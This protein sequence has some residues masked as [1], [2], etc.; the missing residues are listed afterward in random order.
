MSGINTFDSELS[1][2]G[3][4]VVVVASRFND[5]VVDKLIAGALAALRK[6]GVLEADT[7]LVRVPGAWEL[8]LAARELAATEDCDAIIALGCVIRGDTP[9][10]EYVA[11]ECA[12]GLADVQ[13]HGG[14]P[15]AF[16]VLTVENHAQA[17]ERADPAR[18]NKGAEAALAALE[19]ANLLA[20]LDDEAGDER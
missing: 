7:W 13:A 20:H 5:D 16:G 19:M 8:P 6:H 10:F 14:L 9:H 2:E 4:R 12:R 3:L 18:G 17:L 11:G 1:G 15:V